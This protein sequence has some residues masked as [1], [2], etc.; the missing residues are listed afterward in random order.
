MLNEALCV[1][2]S[3]ASFLSRGRF[4]LGASLSAQIPILFVVVVVAAAVVVVI[5]VFSEGAEG[6]AG[7]VLVETVG[8]ACT[9]LW[10]FV[11]KKREREKRRRRRR[12]KKRKKKKKKRKKKK[13]KEKEKETIS[14]S[15]TLVKR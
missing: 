5:S 11:V 7:V 15:S 8:A 3:A 12:K 4:Q 14:S 1:C 13:E 10:S 2:V 6:Q 9:F